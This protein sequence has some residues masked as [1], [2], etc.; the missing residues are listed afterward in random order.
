MDY[1]EKRETG[2]KSVFPVSQEHQVAMENQG[3]K[4]VAVNRVYQDA[5]ELR[6]T[7]VQLVLVEEMVKQEEMD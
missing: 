6:E 4:D 1:K 5:M 2:E 3:L 7:A